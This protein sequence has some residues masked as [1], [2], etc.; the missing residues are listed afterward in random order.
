MV[1]TSIARML[2]RGP[3]L[4]ILIAMLLAA[5]PS[6]GRTQSLDGWLYL[7]ES[8]AIFLSWTTTGS[9]I[10]GTSYWTVYPGLASGYA[11]GGTSYL[12]SLSGTTGGD[13]LTLEI[14][15]TPWGP[16]VWQAAIGDSTLSVAMPTGDGLIGTVQFVR[17]APDGYNEAIIAL[18]DRDAALAAEAARL[19]EEYEQAQT[20]C[21]TRVSGHD[22]TLVVEGRPGAVSMCR[23]LTLMSGV[24]AG[25]DEPRYPPAPPDGSVV[26]QGEIDGYRVWVVDTGGQI[27][28]T[29][30]CRDLDLPSTVGWLGI[31]FTDIWRDDG[32]FGWR[33][34]RCEDGSDIAAGSPAESAGLRIGDRIQAVDEVTDLWDTSVISDRYPG[35]S[36]TLLVARDGTRTEIRV[37]LAARPWDSVTDV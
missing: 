30:A 3:A 7:D 25:W 12:G 35:D 16:Q 32:S 28:G 2:R 20:G 17:S 5:L 4:A 36:V 26:C 27:Y 21:S 1:N 8:Q 9:T 31:C 29:I 18:R 34:S 6:Y 10:D 11:S 33:V 13:R 23:V 24:E 14:A 15:E 19:T 37:V 22:A